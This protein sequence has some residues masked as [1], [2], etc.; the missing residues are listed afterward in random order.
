MIGWA[1][2]DHPI[3]LSSLRTLRGL[4]NP[5]VRWCPL[6]SANTLVAGSVSRITRNLSGVFLPVGLFVELPGDQPVMKG[7]VGIL[8]S[9]GALDFQGAICPVLLPSVSL[10]LC[11]CPAPSAG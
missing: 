4:G 9:S 5:A 7:P 1:V 3:R 6:G 10:S 2:A 8:R 11:A